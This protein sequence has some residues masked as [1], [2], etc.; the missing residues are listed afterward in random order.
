[1]SSKGKNIS[2][3]SVDSEAIRSIGYEPS[4]K[5]LQ[6]EFHGGAVYNYFKVPGYVYERFMKADSKGAVC[7]HYIKNH[8]KFLRVL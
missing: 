2:R 6:V 8:Y 3:T 7:N 5:I 1:M 4:K